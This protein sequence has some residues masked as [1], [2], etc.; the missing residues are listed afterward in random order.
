LPNTDR[1][2]LG[3]NA[4]AEIGGG[5]QLLAPDIVSGVKGGTLRAG[6]IVGPA[7][8]GWLVSAALNF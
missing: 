5:L 1:G 7:V 6:A 2:T 8:T 3:F 4:F